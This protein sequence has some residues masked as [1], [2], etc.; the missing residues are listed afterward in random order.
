MEITEK[1]LMIV[2]IITVLSIV[3][4]CVLFFHGG[5]CDKVLSKLG[6][7]RAK[8]RTNWAIYSW[9]NCLEQ[10]HYDSDIAFIGDSITRGGNFQEYF[11]DKKIINLGYSGDTIVGVT[12]RVSML[13]HIS[14]EKIFIMIG[15]NGLTNM[16]GNICLETYSILLDSIK[17][18]L[19]MAKVYV[20]SVLPVSERKA[21][22]L[23]CNNDTI[24]K[25]NKELKKLSEEKQMTYVDL[26]SVFAE[27][28]QMKAN[29]STDGLHINS[30][31]YEA[32]TN[33]IADHI[34]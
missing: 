29:L 16:N 12:K 4:F 1:Y 21:K 15:I 8:A 22:K 13:K 17:E 7:K 24:K 5:Y 9:D 28:N 19:P 31:G 25:F 20:Q 2:S 34:N 33:A 3:A 30:K 23:V 11:P 10:L 32:W 26:F 27:N 18:I 6:L 14:P